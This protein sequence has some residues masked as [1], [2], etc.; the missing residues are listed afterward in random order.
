MRGLRRAAVVAISVASLALGTSSVGWANDSAGFRYGTDSNGPTNTTGGPPYTNTFS[1]YGTNT[2]LGGIYGGY[3]GRFTSWKMV[4][5]RG[6]NEQVNSTNVTD[7]NANFGAGYGMGTGE[8]DDLGGPG[9]DPN[10]DPS[11]P[12]G[13]EAYAWGAKQGDAAIV[14][15]QNNYNIISGILWGD[16][17]QGEGWNS[18]RTPCGNLISTTECCSTALDRDTVNGFF[19]AIINNGGGLGYG[20][21]ASYY[22]WNQATFGCGSCT[23]GPGYLPGVD[24]WTYGNQVSQNPSTT[25]EPQGWC[26]T[27][28]GTCA[29][30]FGG[31]T[32]ANSTAVLWQW[33]ANNGTTAGDFDQISTSRLG[34]G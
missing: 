14:A 16:M 7:A 25:I 8:I 11:A 22:F 31:Q 34:V 17:E 24:E 2:S 18:Y 29:Q 23:S 33:A 10:Y 12:S 32:S 21:Y 30:F 20:I 3:L 13:A 5:G 15:W 26:V 27:A 4:N 9:V 1:W 28:T 6:N 19:Q